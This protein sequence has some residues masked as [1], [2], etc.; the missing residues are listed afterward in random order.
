MDCRR[1]AERCSCEDL[2][3]CPSRVLLRARG[4]Y[5]LEAHL[6]ITHHFSHHLSPH[7]LPLELH[8]N[9][10]NPPFPLFLFPPFAIGNDIV[11]PFF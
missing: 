1:Y 10:N 8:L 11:F 7:F 5:V 6:P 2:I 4:G 9:S 3:V